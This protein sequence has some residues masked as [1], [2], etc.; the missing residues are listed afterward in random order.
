MFKKRIV[1]NSLFERHRMLKRKRY[2]QPIQHT[3]EGEGIDEALL[4]PVNE[5]P[6]AQNTIAIKRKNKK[7]GPTPE[8]YE[9]INDIVNEIIKDKPPTTKARK[10]MKVLV[11]KLNDDYDDRI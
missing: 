10:L 5:I 1:N 3:I 4:N 7:K 2:E 8:D 11:L 6:K 9:D